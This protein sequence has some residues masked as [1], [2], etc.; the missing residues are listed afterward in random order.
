MISYCEDSQLECT[1]GKNAWVRSSQDGSLIRIEVK[2]SEL[3][4]GGIPDNREY[5][6]FGHIFQANALGGFDYQISGEFS[7]DGYYQNKS[8]ADSFNEGFAT[9]YSMMV[10]LEI[11]KDPIFFRYLK[12]HGESGMELNHKAWELEVS[13]VAGLLVDFV[14]GADDYADGRSPTCLIVGSTEN[15]NGLL[16]SWV[17]NNCLDGD[18]KMTSV[19]TIVV[20]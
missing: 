17:E 13:A 12:D 20:V 19:Q 1:A 9:F 4:D 7:H 8:S 6:E 10:S 2:A 5:L 16:V 18:T 15:R 14:D 3:D 11:D